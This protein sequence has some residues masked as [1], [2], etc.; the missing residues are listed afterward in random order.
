MSATKPAPKELFRN[1][2]ATTLAERDQAEANR[3]ATVKREYD[4]LVIRCADTTDV[5]PAS[6]IAFLDEH[7]FDIDEFQAA[8]VLRCDRTENIKTAATLPKNEKLVTDLRDQ[9]RQAGRDRDEAIAAATAKLNAECE[10]KQ[11]KLQQALDVAETAYRAALDA[12]AFLRDTRPQTTALDRVEEAKANLRAAEMAL[13][14]AKERA[15]PYL[16]SEII[17]KGKEAAPHVR[18]VRSGQHLTYA[19][20]PMH[21]REYSAHEQAYDQY[22]TM[23]DGQ[24]PDPS[25]YAS[26]SQAVEA[27]RAALEA[28][29]ADADTEALTV[30]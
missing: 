15:R 3:Q 20:M 29:L 30:V 23:M 11:T 22:V 25:I 26:E 27:A 21:P 9:I 2:M 17:R 13:K 6:V 8:V 16:D 5:D 10:K 18:A 24:T 14:D 7:G 28:V 12:A 4:A 1:A 19:G